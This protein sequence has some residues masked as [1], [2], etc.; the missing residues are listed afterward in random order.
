MHSMIPREH[1]IITFAINKNAAEVIILKI[2]AE[3]LLFV[4]HKPESVLR[5][6]AF[7][8]VVGKMRLKK[9][10]MKGVKSDILAA[11]CGPWAVLWT[12]LY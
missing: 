2:H 10:N 8:K 12:A 5:K 9:S 7:M 3:Q 11:A 1:A 6:K 4:Q